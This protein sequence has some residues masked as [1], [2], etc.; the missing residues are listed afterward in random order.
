MKGGCGSCGECMHGRGIIYNTGKLTSRLA[1]STAL[2]S[3]PSAILLNCLH[4]DI[5]KQKCYARETCSFGN[6]T[7]MYEPKNQRT[8]I[9]LKTLILLTYVNATDKIN[10][11][12][13]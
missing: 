4:A 1:S 2:K 11:L 10:F 6:H 12:D 13:S 5:V 8:S 3:G 9:S 7:S